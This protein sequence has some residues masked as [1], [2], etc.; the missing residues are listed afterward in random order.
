MRKINLIIIFLSFFIININAQNDTTYFDDGI[1]ETNKEEYKAAISDYSKAIKI[2]PDYADAYFYRGCAKHKLKDYKG[3]ISDFSKAIKVN[4]NYVDAYYYRGLAKD[5]LARF[6]SNKNK[7]KVADPISD[8]LMEKA[9]GTR[10]SNI[11]RNLSKINY[12]GLSKEGAEET[13][14]MVDEQLHQLLSE[15]KNDSVESKPM[16]EAKERAVHL[17]K[18]EKQLQETVIEREDLKIEVDLYKN[19]LILVALL[20]TILST[21]I[22]LITRNLIQKKRIEKLNNEIIKQFD[23][24]QSKN[25]FLEYSARLIRHDMHSGINTYMPR[26]LSSLEKR[27]TEEDIK[28]LKIESPLKMI[29]E[30]LNHTQKVYKEIYNFSNLVKRETVLEKENVNIKEVLDNFL[31]TTGYKNQV[32]LSENLPNLDINSYLVCIAMDHLIKNGLKY[33]DSENKL[34]KIYSEDEYICLEDNGRGMTQEEFIHLSKPYVRKEGQK[35]TGDGIGLNISLAILKEHNFT[36]TSEKIDPIGT[37]LKIKI[38]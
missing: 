8:S 36:V 28:N 34:V 1:E 19:W 16:K 11:L 37:K 4:P 31:K 13:L 18:K 7:K 2:N 14:K 10:T 9:L 24:I 12:H 27:L 38:R 29:K 32:E 35:E 25:G 30:G 22:G 20:I 6:E 5:D 17:L 33:N 3:A 23:D 21:I 15:S 26:G